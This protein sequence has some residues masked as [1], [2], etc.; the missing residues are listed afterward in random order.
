MTDWT[1]CNTYTK[2]FS[3]KGGESFEAPI[4]AQMQRPITLPQGQPPLMKFSFPTASV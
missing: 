4:G 1:N 3:D 2:V